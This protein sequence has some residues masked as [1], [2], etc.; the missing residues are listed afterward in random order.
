MASVNTPA[1]PMPAVPPPPAPS[2]EIVVQV[3]GR[4]DVGRTRDH[5]ED[6]FIVAD[7]TA[8]VATVP[9]EVRRTITGQ[10][11]SLFQRFEPQAIAISPFASGMNT[12]GAQSRRAGVHKESES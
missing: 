4:T 7:L 9:T 6:A 1:E 8:D 2:D 11:G 10:K 3:F 5:N 12:T